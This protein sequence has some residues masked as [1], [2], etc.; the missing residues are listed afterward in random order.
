MSID[1]FTGVI[2]WTPP[3]SGDYP[4]TVAATNSAGADS[5]SYMIQVSSAVNCPAGMVAY[6][7]FDETG[8]TVCADSS[9]NLDATF[10]GGGSPT[11]ASGQL[12]GAVDL[13]G[14][15]QGYSTAGSTNP[16][17]GI[18]LMAW[19]NPDDLS[20]RDRGIITKKDAF[21]LEIESS[22][23]EVS[24]TI[25]NGG[26]SRE[27]EPD[28]FAGND[29]PTGAWTHIAA[30]FDGVTTSIYING[31]LAASEASV[32]NALGGSGEPYWIGWNSQTN[33]GTDRYFDGR[34]DEAAVFDRALDA[35]EV[36]QLYQNS[37]LGIDYCSAST[38]AQR[39]SGR[40]AL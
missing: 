28:V 6:W 38:A 22:G 9:G 40:L 32:F 4:V 24:F 8:G 29:I 1:P 18:T 35:G 39:I 21:I 27:F 11:F 7:K 19:I 34:I 2:T 37:S 20:A 23:A 33:F 12:N 5:Q 30:T 16:T 36:Q 3:A 15:N 25:L 26:M 13:N 17:A 14:T 31:S 10:S